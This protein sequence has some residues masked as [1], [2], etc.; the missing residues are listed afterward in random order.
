MSACGDCFGAAVVAH[1]SGN[2]LQNEIQ[3]GWMVMQLLS[4]Q[5]VE[6]KMLY[7]ICRNIK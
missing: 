3:K 7:F 1:L 5:D 4:I 2:G 6:E